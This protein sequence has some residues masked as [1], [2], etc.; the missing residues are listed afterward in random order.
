MHDYCSRTPVVWLKQSYLELSSFTFCVSWRWRLL[1]HSFSVI[2][3]K[4][5]ECALFLLPICSRPRK[6]IYWSSRKI[7]VAKETYHWSW[8]IKKVSCQNKAL[9]PIA[10]KSQKK[11]IKSGRSNECLQRARNFINLI[12]VQKF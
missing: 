8:R 2:C 6:M 10:I 12:L 1:T 7:P 4:N 3:K 5:A 11:L 9:C